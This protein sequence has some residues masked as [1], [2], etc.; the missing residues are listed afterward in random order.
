MNYVSLWQYFPQQTIG[1][2]LIKYIYI[3]IYILKK[4]CVEMFILSNVFINDKHA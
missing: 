1:A 4:E 3:Y 2:F